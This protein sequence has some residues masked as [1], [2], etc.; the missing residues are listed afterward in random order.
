MTSPTPEIGPVIQRHRKAGGLT[1]EQLAD[2][3]GVSKSMLSQI[4]RGQA[5]PTFAV[6]WGLTRALKIELTD[7]VDA[8]ALNAAAGSIEI[9]SA[10]GT[11]EMKSPDGLCRLRIYSPPGLAGSNEWYMIDIAEGGVLDSAP[12]SPG[13][14]E[15]LTVL[16]GALT[17][18]S[19]VAQQV[20][21]AGETARYQADTAHRIEHRGDGT[22]RALLVVL[23]PQKTSLK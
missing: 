23:F 14:T 18:S 9:V 21:N 15:H 10:P 19:G 1:L 4:E 22:A 8:S 16:E 2:L 7:L 5:N 6:L 11:P 12:H 20:V 13:A 3:S 17:V